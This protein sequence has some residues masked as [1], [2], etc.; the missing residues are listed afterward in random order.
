MA[1]YF[2]MTDGYVM[3]AS[4]LAVIPPSEEN[5]DYKKY[6]SDLASGAIVE[7]FDYAAEDERQRQAK[8][9]SAML[10]VS[11]RQ[12]RQALTRSGLRTQVE[13]A[14]AAGD[15]DLKDWWEFALEVE[16]DHPQVVAMAAALG[17]N[18]ASLANLFELAATL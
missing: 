4:D 11:P 5:D 2:T 18:D 3:R 10:T 6:M 7:P 1:D 14:V 9:K 17:V 8:I 15:N 12:I 13:S 16:Q